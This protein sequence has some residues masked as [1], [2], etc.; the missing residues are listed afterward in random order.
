[1]HRSKLGNPV[2][3]RCLAVGSG[4]AHQ[5]HFFLKGALY[6]CVD[7]PNPPCGANRSPQDCGNLPVFVPGKMLR[8]QI[9]RIRSLRNRLCDKL[10]AIRL[11]EPGT[12]NKCIASCHA[13]LS[14]T[15]FLD[16]YIQ[17]CKVVRQEMSDFLPDDIGGT[18]MTLSSG[19]SFGTLSAC[20][21]APVTLLDIRRLPPGHR[22]LAFCFGLSY[23]HRPTRPW[24]ML[25]QT[26][27]RMAT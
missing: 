20:S 8:S 17:F 9:H 27:K 1:M 10:P 21:A 2:A 3:G 23:H 26:H 15:S 18:V 5:P 24:S 7:Q 14:V 19:A 12:G 4:N 6:N 22:I 16:R 11:L 13:R 25:A